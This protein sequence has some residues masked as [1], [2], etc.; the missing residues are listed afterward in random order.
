MIGRLPTSPARTPATSGRCSADAVAAVAR[1]VRG[2]VRRD[3]RPICAARRHRRRLAQAGS[4]LGVAGPGFP[5]TLV[6]RAGGDRVDDLLLG[7]LRR[8]RR[9]RRAAEAQHRDPVG[10]LE[11]VVQVVRDEHDAR[12]PSR[13]GASRARAPAASAR[14]RARRSARRGSRAASSTSR[15]SRPR[16]TGAGRPRGW[17]PSAGSSG[18]SSPTGPSSSRR[19]SPPSRLVEDDRRIGRARGR[20]TCSGRRRGCRTSAR[21]W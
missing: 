15:P 21:S 12:G 7:R 20:G 8:A 13:P 10:H 14:R 18:S 3:G 2:R 11:D 19:S 6:Q 4:S 16:P 9:R 5:G 17:R 1:P